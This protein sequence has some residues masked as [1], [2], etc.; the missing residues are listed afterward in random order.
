MDRYYDAITF[1]LM[2]PRVAIFAYIIKIVNMI[3]K[4][5]FKDSK[6]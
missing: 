3:I 4:T 6:S 5:T 1:I 2:W